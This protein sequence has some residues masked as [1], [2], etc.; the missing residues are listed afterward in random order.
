ME[1]VNKAVEYLIN[2]LGS[3][4]VAVALFGSRARGEASE[5]SDY[6]FLVVVRNLEEY[7]R[8][9]I[10]YHYLYKVLKKDITIIDIDEKDI[11]GDKLAITPLLLNIAWDSIIL[12]DSNGKLSRLF[13]EIRRVFGEKL[14]RYRTRDGKYGWKP[15]AGELR[16][17]NFEIEI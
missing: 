10:I 12:Y 1:E 4:V 11:F 5:N 7:N 9:F 15:K 8:R 6:D 14:V 16:E 17:F 13:S 3:K 2:K